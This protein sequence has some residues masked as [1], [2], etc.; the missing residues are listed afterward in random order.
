MYVQIYYKTQ[1]DK[2]N[3]SLLV[4]QQMYKIEAIFLS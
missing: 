4:L 3:F 2:M 1:N